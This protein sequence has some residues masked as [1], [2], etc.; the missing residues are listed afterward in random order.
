MPGGSLE[1]HL[2]LNDYSILG[3]RKRMKIVVEAAKGLQFLHGIDQ[4]VIYR[5]FKASNIL[6]DSDYNAKLS[7][8]GLAKDGPLGDETHVSTRVMGTQGYAAP[9]YVMTGHL[10]TK[11]D[12]FCFGVVLLELLTGMRSFDSSRR[13][14]KKNLVNWV[15]P[16][17]EDPSTFGRL[18]DPRLQ[19]KYS[20]KAVETVVKL[21]CL[22]L[23]YNPKDRPQMSTVVD[24]LEPIKDLDIDET[25]LEPKDNNTIVYH[26]HHKN[27]PK[28][29]KPS[30][31]A[32]SDITLPR[33]IWIC[34]TP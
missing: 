9:E 33:K 27:L 10:T 5:D 18:I 12:V 29:Q 19:G 1:D 17:L 30:L 31:K 23:S 6:L 14:K 22:C 15:K 34:K 3:W 4:P 7:D 24:T 21:T 32:R 26:T 25:M 8:F 20:I 2:F 16:Y 28:L 11:S 13:G